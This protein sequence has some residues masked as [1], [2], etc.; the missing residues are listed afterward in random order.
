MDAGGWSR[1]GQSQLRTA[2]AR[3]AAE[4]RWHAD[5][6]DPVVTDHVL[7]AVVKARLMLQSTSEGLGP[8]A[9]TVP[10]ANHSHVGQPVVRP[11]MTFGGHTRAQDA[12]AKCSHYAP[13]P[14]DRGWVVRDRVCTSLPRPM[15]ARTQ[16]G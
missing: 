4:A 7:P 5:H 10:D 1:V 13:G 11:G 6:I 8:I 2:W 14:M 12:D 15:T 9:R 16:R 3:T